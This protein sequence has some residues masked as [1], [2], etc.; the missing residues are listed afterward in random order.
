[1]TRRQTTRPISWALLL[2]SLLV[3][4]TGLVLLLGFHV[5]QGRFRAELLGLSRL[6]WLNLHRL[7]SV[8]V[9]LCLAA[10]LAL[11][12]RTL[13][14]RLQRM[15]TRTT[16]SR[17][18]G[19]LVLYLAFT[20]MA[21]TGLAAWMSG[22]PP[23]IGPVALGAIPQPRHAV[24]DAHFLSGIISLLLAAHHVGHRYRA[25]LA[26]RRAKHARAASAGSF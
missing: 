10:H 26:R 14:A 15:L 25:L 4:V 16:R 5:G 2:S 6:T 7:P 3:F 13:T 17:D 23:L 19:E 9:L 21:V 20:L 18:R 1:M 11:H 12:W 22:S 8:L 24:I